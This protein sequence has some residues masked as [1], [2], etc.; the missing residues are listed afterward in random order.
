M[1]FFRKNSNPPVLRHL[2][3]V[4]D[5]RGVETFVLEAS[6]YSIGRDPSNAI[7]IHT[8]AVSRQHAILLRMPN[9]DKTYRYAIQDGNLEGKPSVNGIIVNGRPAKKHILEDGDEI[10][11]GGKAT[12]TYRTPI[13]SDQELEEKVTHPEFRRLKGNVIGDIQT[14]QVTD[15][16]TKLQSA[17]PPN[18]IKK[19]IISFR[20]CY[21]FVLQELRDLNLE[22]SDYITIASAIY[23]KIKE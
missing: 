13:L 18:S 22:K 23:Q 19:E 7:V 3:T 12:L 4:N 20:Q 14:I 15:I 11:I 21:E 2:L 10:V 16:P 8:D 5:D 9:P 1:G 6:V 17:N